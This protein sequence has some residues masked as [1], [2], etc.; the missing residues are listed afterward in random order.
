VVKGKF[1]RGEVPDERKPVIRDDD[2]DDDDDDKKK[3]KKKG[4]PHTG[5]VRSCSF[6]TLKSPIRIP[7]LYGGALQDNITQRRVDMHPAG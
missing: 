4:A 3:K 7:S 5:R 2:D 1:S 6:R